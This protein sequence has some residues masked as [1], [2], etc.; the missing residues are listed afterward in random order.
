[1]IVIIIAM[2]LREQLSKSGDHQLSRRR[3]ARPPIHIIRKIGL[4]LERNR[5]V[6]LNAV[7]FNRQICDLQN[8]M[9]SSIL[10][11][12]TFKSKTWVLLF[13]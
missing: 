7:V 13:F 3:T 9:K 4:G 8:E 2:Q 1:M 11:Y 10:H 12:I 6:M 5:S